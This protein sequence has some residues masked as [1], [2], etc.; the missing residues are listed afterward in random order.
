MKNMKNTT[1]DLVMEAETEAFNSQDEPTANLTLLDHFRL[2][3][4]GVSWDGDN[5]DQ[6]EAEE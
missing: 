6:Q 2:H 1:A 5:R 4:W 3:A